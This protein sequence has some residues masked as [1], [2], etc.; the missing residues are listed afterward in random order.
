MNKL[1]G[2]SA[3][4]FGVI[5]IVVA[6]MTEVQYTREEGLYVSFNLGNAIPTRDRYET[7]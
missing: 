6:I 4:V 5:A 3:I 2:Q 1:K 7:S